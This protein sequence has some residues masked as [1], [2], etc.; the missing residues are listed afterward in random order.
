MIT[1]IDLDKLSDEINASDSSV[2]ALKRQQCQV[3]D[4]IKNIVKS[5]AKYRSD[6]L[7]E[8]LKVLN[9]EKDALAAKIEAAQH[10]EVQLVQADLPR[11]KRDLKQYL[12]KSTDLEAKQ[13][14]KENVDEITVDNTGL[15]LKLRVV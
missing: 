3:E 10:K 6:D 5:L 8:Q 15:N 11:A 12:R 4:K 13:Y 7:L 9:A 2:K 1:G 14:I